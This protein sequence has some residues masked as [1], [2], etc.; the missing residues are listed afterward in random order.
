MFDQ[1]CPLSTKVFSVL[2]A[3]QLCARF[4]IVEKEYKE[5]KKIHSRE[6]STLQHKLLLFLCQARK[7]TKYRVSKKNRLRSNLVLAEND[8]IYKICFYI[9]WILILQLIV[10]YNYKEIQNRLKVRRAMANEIRA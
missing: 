5:Y 6:K 8:C 7:P 10:L 2:Y 1:I 9:F 4:V 3:L